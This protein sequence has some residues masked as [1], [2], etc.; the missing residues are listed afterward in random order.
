[1]TRKEPLLTLLAAALVAGG[2]MAAD[3]GSRFDD[4]AA[5]VSPASVTPATVTPT[6]APAATTPAADETPAAAPIDADADTGS[7]Y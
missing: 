3:I 5:T 2:L 4:G 6:P 7:G 1:M